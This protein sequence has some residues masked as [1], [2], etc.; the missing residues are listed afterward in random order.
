[1]DGPG[2]RTVRWVALGIIVYPLAMLPLLLAAGRWDWTSA[3]LGIAFLLTASIF[4]ARQ[5]D[6]H[7]PGLFARRSQLLPETPHWDRHL[8]TSLKLVV[9]VILVTAGLEYRILGEA[10][11]PARFCLGLVLVVLGLRLL[12]SSQKANPFFEAYVR[13]QPDMGQVVVAQGPYGYVRHPGYLAYLG[14]FAA[15]P[16]LLSS[17]AAW[18]PFL[19]LVVLFVVRLLKE[20]AFL[21]QNLDGYTDYCRKVRFRLFPGF[22]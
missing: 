9:I 8:V 15:L 4:Q 12:H 20:E 6:L 16:C 13:H 10:F 18:L 11:H 3:H 5:I 22:W 1:M 21:K 17:N 19:L 2:G 7:N 14:M